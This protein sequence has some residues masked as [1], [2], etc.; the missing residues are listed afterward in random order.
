MGREGISPSPLHAF[1]QGGKER[2]LIRHIFLF[3]THTIGLREGK[4]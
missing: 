4:G 1:V 3:P 2:E